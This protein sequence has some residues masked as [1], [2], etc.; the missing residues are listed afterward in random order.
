MNALGLDEPTLVLELFLP[1]FEFF[2]NGGYGRRPPF[3]LD[4]IM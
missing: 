1:P 2:K 4:Y 3:R